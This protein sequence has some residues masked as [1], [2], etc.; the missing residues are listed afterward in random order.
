MTKEEDFKLLKIQ[1][2]QK[3][4]S[5]NYGDGGD[6]FDDEEEDEEDDISAAT[7]AMASA[8]NTGKINNN[9]NNNP[10]GMKGQQNQN[11]GMKASP[12]GEIDPKTLATLSMSSN[13]QFVGRNMNAAVDGRRASDLNNMMNLGGFHGNGP[14]FSTC[15]GSGGNPINGLGGGYKLQ[16]NNNGFSASSTG[17]PNGYA[18]GQYPPSMMNHTSSTSSSSPNP[19]MTN[20]NMN[21]IICI[22]NQDKMP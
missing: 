14:N 1:Q 11:M 4:A 20:M 19:M 5:F 22:I 16:S 13:P 8:Q 21:M 15:V 6:D 17:L 7:A 2:Q 10:H 12:H 18:T 9:G 3:F